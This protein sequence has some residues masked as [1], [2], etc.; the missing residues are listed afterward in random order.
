MTVRGFT[1]Y[2]MLVRGASVRGD[3]PAVIQDGR[4]TGFAELLRRVDALAAGLA[5]LGVAR[6]DRVCVLAQNDAA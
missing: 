6:G 1:L 3:A 2:D 5:G 4:E